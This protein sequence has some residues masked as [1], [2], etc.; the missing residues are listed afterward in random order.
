MRPHQY[1]EILKRTNRQTLL[2]PAPA[3]EIPGTEDTSVGEQ[4]LRVFRCLEDGEWH[5]AKELAKAAGYDPVKS[6]DAI[7]ARC[8]D[9]R[10][11]QYG[12]HLVKW[13]RAGAGFGG[14]E[15]RL[16]LPKPKLPLQSR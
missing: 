6:L 16:I 15:Y 13:R 5:P 9:L 10:K 3:P 7:G 8:R 12:G 4:L 11:P 1:R 14:G 2:G